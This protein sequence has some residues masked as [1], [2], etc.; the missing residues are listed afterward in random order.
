MVVGGSRDREASVELRRGL[1]FQNC[2]PAASSRNC[3]SRPPDRQS[4]ASGGCD[5]GRVHR[6][7]STRKVDDLVKALGCDS[8][9]SKLTVS[10]ICAQIDGDVH[11]LRTRRLSHQ[12]FV[13]V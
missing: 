12:L 4:L 2:A 7:T 6:R 8:E 9:I 5:H 13:N 11:V 1:A 3:S 10:R